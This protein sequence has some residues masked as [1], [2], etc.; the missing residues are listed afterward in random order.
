MKYTF[1]DRVSALSPSAIREI[2]KYSAGDPEVVPLSAGNPSPEAFPT[3]EVAAIS[4]RLLRTRPIDALQYSLTE[5]YPA[6]RDRLK[7]YMSEQHRAVRDTDEL[8]ITAGAQQVMGLAVKVLCNEGDGVICEDPSFIGSLNS[9]RSLGAKLIGVPV[10]SDGMSL[11]ALEAALTAH[12]ETRFIYTIPNFQNP[13]GV[14]M[15]LEKR[16]GVYALAKRFGVLILEDNPYG[17]LRFAGEP[18]PTIKSMDEDGIVLYAGSFSKVLAPGLRVGYALGPQPLIAK[19]VVA[20]QGEDVHTNIWA[21]MI[22]D[23]FMQGDFAGHLDKLRAI[24][25]AKAA[26]MQTLI[27]QYLVPAGITYHPVQGGLFMWCTL[28]EGADM[29]AFCRRAVVEHKVAVVPGSAFLADPDTPCS[30]FRVNYST[31]TDEAMTRGIQRL[32]AFAQTF[33]KEGK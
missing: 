19:M 15:S 26:H 17:D 30:S 31:P 22:C 1:S 16:R 2:L 14:T 29:P 33:L 5:G 3:E 7:R 4:D 27:E 13:T 32:G 18:L 24:Y 23:E 8:I 6:L 28:P 25:R 11:T 12:P 10:E 21:Q 20:K 9:F